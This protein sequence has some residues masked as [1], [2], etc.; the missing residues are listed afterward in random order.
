MFERELR[1][2]VERVPGVRW[3]GLI[4]LDGV[5]VAQSGGASEVPVDELAASYADLIR[6]IAA[7]HREVDVGPP[8][9]VVMSSHDARIVVR[10]VTVDYGLIAILGPEASLGRARYE[11]HKAALNLRPE[12]DD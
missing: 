2:P 6:R 1:A 10:T 8:S 12:L 11:L 7:T 4:G 5:P 3:V 9:E